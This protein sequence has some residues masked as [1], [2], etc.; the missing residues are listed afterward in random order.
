MNEKIV[1]S[2]HSPACSGT[3]EPADCTKI[4]KLINGIQSDYTCTDIGVESHPM[5]AEI[6]RIFN[7]LNDEEKI[8]LKTKLKH[9]LINFLSTL[10]EMAT[11]VAQSRHIKKKFLETGMIDKK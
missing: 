5:K 8:R 9:S 11:T 4:F 10:P 6:S 1:A 2:K 7:F 3:K